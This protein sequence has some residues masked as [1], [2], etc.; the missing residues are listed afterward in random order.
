MDEEM[1][2]GLILRGYVEPAG[3]DTKTGE[4]LYSFTDLAKYEMPDLEKQFEEAFHK[5]IMFFWQAGALDMNV[6]EENPIIRINPLAFEQSFIDSLT[7]E[8]SM[9]LK[10]IIDAL[11]IT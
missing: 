5:N 3:M 8:Q 4:M 1:L 11:R 9:A 10:I 6:Y 2:E 7:T